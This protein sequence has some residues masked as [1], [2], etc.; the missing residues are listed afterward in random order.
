LTKQLLTSQLA[1]VLLCEQS[2]VYI[3]AIGL[4][5]LFGGS[6]AATVVPALVF[7]SMLRA[8]GLT[9]GEFYVIQRVLPVQLVI[10]PSLV[11]AFA[12]LVSLCIAALGMMA[13][14]VS[15]PSISQTL[16]LNED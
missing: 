15:K 13:H 3:T 7:T 1:R 9:S 14:I 16:H 6:L 11:F 2:V 12:V 10:P 5:T 8:A 4:G